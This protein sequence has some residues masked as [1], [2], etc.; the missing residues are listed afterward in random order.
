MFNLWGC[1]GERAQ[2]PS[3]WGVPAL[4]GQ[5]S[6]SCNKGTNSP[7][8]PALLAVRWIKSATTR[9]PGCAELRVE[10]LHPLPLTGFKAY[11]EGRAKAQRSRGKREMNSGPCSWATSEGQRAQWE[12][13]QQAWRRWNMSLLISVSETYHF[14]HLP[15]QKRIFELTA[16][17]ELHHLMFVCLQRKHRR[18][19][20]DRWN[21]QSF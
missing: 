2:L 3:C 13:L 15:G 16:L 6:S 5:K 11:A 8:A 20:S 4:A 9:Q 14:K 18:I 10:K 19:V 17:E 21:L 7:L 12:F 1:E